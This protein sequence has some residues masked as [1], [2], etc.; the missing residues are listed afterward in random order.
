MTYSKL[1]LGYVIK[2]RNLEEKIN[3]ALLNFPVVL[4]VGARQVG[5]SSLTKSLRSDWKYFDLENSSHYELITRDFDF[6]FSQ[7][8]QNIIID[9][10]QES[11][12]LF[13]NLR[14]VIDQK[15]DLKNRFLL[16]GSSSLELLKAASDSLAGRIAVFEI[17]TF[18]LNE[19]KEEKLPEIY[20]LLN[21]KLTKKN[22][23][24]FL[25]NFQPKKSNEDLLE[26][27]LLGGYPEARKIYDEDKSV[28]YDW[29]QN[30]YDSY[31][32]K[33][34]KRLFPKLNEGKFGKFIQ[35]LSSL[36]GKLVNKSEL[37]RSIDVSEVTIKH[38]LEVAEGTFLWQNLYSFESSH[39][40]SIIKT[41][42]GV[43]R[44][45]GLLHFIQKIQNLDDLFLNPQLGRNF[46]GFIV[47]EF[48]KG[49]QATNAKLLSFHHYRTRAHAE[50]DFILEGSF[51]KLPIEI[52]FSS[53]TRN[54]KLKTLERFIEDHGLEY[55]FVIN[56]SDDFHWLSEK[57]L[58]V[59]AKY[60]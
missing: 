53:H 49:A 5:K 22:L 15:R 60:I 52:K 51:G 27:F 10:A 32:K 38:Y 19:V 39:I 26:H 8:S 28:Y 2:K 50:I 37:G 54:Q 7:Y 55:G 13:R 16:T 46:E 33:D 59:P 44:D 20:S 11:P 58:Q 4:L 17:P 57:I 48:I 31:L 21:N 41:S 29:M 18:K 3:K 56:Q 1:Y 14:G 47:E 36:S 25:K 12:E 40:K 35:M 45:S 24:V 30:Y 9:E 34:V 43:L 23:E 6:F 42:K